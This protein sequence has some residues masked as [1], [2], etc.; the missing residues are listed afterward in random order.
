MYGIATCGT[1]ISGMAMHL[2]AMHLMAMHE[3]LVGKH[4]FT[5]N[6]S[7]SVH[8]CEGNTCTVVN[9]CIYKLPRSG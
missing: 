6:M 3:T 4:V 2:M 5:K 1:R 9:P 7:N 8:N